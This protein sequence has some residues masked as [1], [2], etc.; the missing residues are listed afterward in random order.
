MRQALA[1]ATDR[2]TIIQYLLRGQV[3]PAA[4]LLPPNHWAYEPNVQQYD[5]DPARAEKLL[6]AAGFRAERMACG[7]V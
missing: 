4:S 1:Y 3:R 5:F 2:A 6:D 7:C